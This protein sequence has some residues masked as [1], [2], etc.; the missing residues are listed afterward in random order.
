M[1]FRTHNLFHYWE[2]ISVCSV[3]IPHMWHITDSSW[4]VFPSSFYATCHLQ[5][6]FHWNTD[7]NRTRMRALPTGQVYHRA[8]LPGGYSQIRMRHQ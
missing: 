3:G 6:G 1:K 7:T 2:P 4:Q 8:Y 5:G